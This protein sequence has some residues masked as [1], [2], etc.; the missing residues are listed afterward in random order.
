M[1]RY[2]IS[3][4]L[5]FALPATALGTTWIV[6]PNGMGNF[7]TIQAAV[8]GSINGDII[9]LT[10]GYFTGPGN[11]DVYIYQKTLTIRSQTGDPNTTEIHP[12]GDES[13]YHRAFY[14]ENLSSDF[15]LE[16]IGITSGFHDDG[17][18]IYC[19][20]ANPT[21]TNCVFG[22]NFAW[23]D[24]GGAYLANSN[25]NFINC[26]FIFNEADYGAGICCWDSHAT[27]TDCEF[28]RNSALLSGGGLCG[29]SYSNITLENC[30]FDEN[31]VV[32]SGGGIYCREASSISATAT[33]F[34][35]NEAAAGG[36]V[37]GHT[38]RFN[39]GECEIR[40]NSAA[41]GAGLFISDPDSFAVLACT[42]H[43]NSGNWGGG[44]FLTNSGTS[45][46]IEDCEFTENHAITG[47]GLYFTDY[48]SPSI[49]GC[50]F[51]R[52][53]AGD[54]GGGGYF[55]Y[56]SNCI[57]GSCTFFE[58]TASDGAC[59]ALAME[60][61]PVVV[62]S[63]FSFG[64]IGEAVYC[65]AQPGNPAFYCCDVYGNEGGD[66]V[67]CIAGYNNEL[68]NFSADPQFCDAP[69]DDLTLSIDSPCLPGNHPNGSNCGRIGAHDLG[70]D[71]AAINSGFVAGKGFILSAQPNPFSSTTH[72]TWATPESGAARLSIFDI[73]GRRINQF[74]FLGS[75]GTMIWDGTDSRGAPA[76]PGTY[77][78]QLEAGTTRGT[79]RITVLR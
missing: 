74:E 48:S 66:Y 41:S 56:E 23:D 28:W 71:P 63:I 75:I 30:I 77:L 69:I 22:A 36:G 7:P 68:G 27:F 6:Q 33:T 61:Y 20:N 44:I 13:N 16:G 40:H 50:T 18:A 25:P 55:Q 34:E 29:R 31:K 72:L 8:D 32:Q 67:G 51:M 5:V 47:G 54:H 2:N 14:F 60:S 42:F 62:S 37:Y 59:L 21:I 39:L 17:G 43:A 49:T 19:L 78:L 53:W 64:I 26:R 52:N 11:R 65:F 70:C 35:Y 45:N 57:M 76:A 1:L 15:C 58:N 9:E 38:A 24:G 73:A 4:L 10:D 46:S 79:K 12:E 3:L